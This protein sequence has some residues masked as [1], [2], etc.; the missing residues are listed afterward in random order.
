MAQDRMRHQDSDS[1]TSLFCLTEFVQRFNVFGRW[2]SGWIEPQKVGSATITA[3]QREDEERRQ[4]GAVRDQRL[5]PNL[6]RKKS[7]VRRRNNRP[8]VL[9]SLSPDRD[10][11]YV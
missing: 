11:T 7:C 5:A 6:Y 10:W 8:H 9:I 4:V 2:R 1:K 3:V